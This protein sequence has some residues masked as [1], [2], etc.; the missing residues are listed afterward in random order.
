MSNPYFAFCEDFYINMRLGSQLNL[1]HS[2]ETVLHFFERIQKEFPGMSRFRK[3]DANELNLE[4]DRNDHSYRWTA[5]EAR[6]LASGHVNPPDVE[7]AL[8]PAQP[9]APTGAL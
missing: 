8:R 4:E 3:N 2:R 6:R 9:A 1:P 7:E 5:L